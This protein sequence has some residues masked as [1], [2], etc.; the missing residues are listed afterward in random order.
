MLEEQKAE[1]LSGPL[2]FGLLPGE[3]A[4]SAIAPDGES[5]AGGDLLLL[6]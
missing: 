5:A 1:A 2:L 3:S 6:S 4:R